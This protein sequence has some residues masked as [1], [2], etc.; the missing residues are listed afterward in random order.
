MAITQRLWLIPEERSPDAI[1]G[2]RTAFVWEYVRTKTCAIVGA[3]SWAHTWRNYSLTIGVNRAD[4]A[5]GWK[6]NQS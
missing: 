6:W 5:A 3:R 1:A 2:G 4:T